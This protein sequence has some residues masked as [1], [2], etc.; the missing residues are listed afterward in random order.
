MNKSFQAGQWKNSHTPC[1][2]VPLIQLTSFFFLLPWIPNA[3]SDVS[4]YQIS[5]ATLLIL[6]F[7]MHSMYVL[8]QFNSPQPSHLLFFMLPLTPNSCSDVSKCDRSMATLLTLDFQMHPK[9]M[10]P[11][12]NSPWASHLLFFM[13]P[14]TPNACCDVGK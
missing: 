12:S 5:M 7:Q 11:Q 4:K 10:I 14:R 1:R 3:C 13:L 6:D 9:Y 2:C 8:P